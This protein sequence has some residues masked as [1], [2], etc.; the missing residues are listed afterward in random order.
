MKSEN[1]KSEFRAARLSIIGAG[2]GDIDLITIKAIKTLGSADVVLYDALVN[3]EL[4]KYA[5]NAEHIFVGKKLGCYAYIQDQI[6]EL[7]VNRA[8][9][10]GHVVRLKGGDPFVF[11]R[12]AEEMEY[13]AN[14]GLEVAMVPGISSSLWSQ[15]HRTFL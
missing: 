7:I 8:K 13:A 10:L 5:P 12:G 9:T 6:N 4:L 11:G 1:P 2:P 15:L 14:H 3:T